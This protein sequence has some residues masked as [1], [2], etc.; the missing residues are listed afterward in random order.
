MMICALFQ[1]IHV[2]KIIDV[3]DDRATCYVTELN[4]VIEYFDEPST[5]VSATINSAAKS[6][7]G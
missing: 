1:G 6:I 4:A 5:D 7:D 3:M 2:V